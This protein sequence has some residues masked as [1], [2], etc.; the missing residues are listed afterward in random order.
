VGLLKGRLGDGVGGVSPAGLRALEQQYNKHAKQIEQSLR[1][2]EA[3]DAQ[4][5]QQVPGVLYEAGED[6][7]SPMAVLHLT[8]L[9]LG[10]R[11]WRV[12]SAI[13]DAEAAAASGSWP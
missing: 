13:D 9:M 7:E 3:L 1:A 12:R 4:F 8:Y 6:G 2:F 5:E 11:E 10:Q